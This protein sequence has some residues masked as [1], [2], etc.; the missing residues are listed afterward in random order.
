MKKKIHSL[1][2]NPSE[3]SSLNYTEL[4]HVTTK[5]FYNPTRSP[6]PRIIRIS[7]L[8]DD[9]TDSDDDD[10]DNNRRKVVKHINEIKFRSGHK[11]ARE[12]GYQAQVQ[13][14]KAVA[15]KYRGVRRRPWG[16][17]A[18][19]IRDPAR[20]TRLWL[21]TYDTAEEAAMVYDNAAVQLRGPHAPTNFPRPPRKDVE[22][23]RVPSPTSVLTFQSQD[24]TEHQSQS[25]SQTREYNR[26][27][28]EKVEPGMGMGMGNEEG[29]MELDPWALNDFFG[30]DNTPKS[31]FGD[32][33][34]FDDLGL[35]GEDWFSG[36]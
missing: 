23:Q 32:I 22:Q 25:Q 14:R 20:R 27:P 15:V 18:A 26:K 31:I 1:A 9:A 6:A 36:A 34:K 28:E 17:Y 33:F 7:F 16:K 12:Q 21:G 8:D 11:R 2:M 13:V 29:E 24:E 4:R 35:D 3:L 10:D 30:Y 19:E 5:V